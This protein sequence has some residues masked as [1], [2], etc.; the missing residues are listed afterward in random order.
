MKK[1]FLILFLMFSV[2]AFSQIET[3]ASNITID[4]GE[5]NAMQNWLDSNGGATA[6]ANCGT[7]TWSNDFLGITDL[8]DAEITVTFT[9]SNS[10]GD[11]QTLATLTIQ[12][13]Q[14]PTIISF[15]S[16]ITLECGS[17]DTLPE[18]VAEDNCSSNITISFFEDI[19]DGS[20]L[21]EEIIMRT[22]TVSDDC[23][24]ITTHLQTISFA[25]YTP[26]SIIT[27]ALDESV[28]CDG[29][30]NVSELNN[31]LSSNG[32]A[33]ASDTCST[34]SWSNDFTVLDS[35]CSETVSATVTFLATDDCGN[36]SSTTAT[37][38]IEVDLN[39]CPPNGTF[40]SQAEIDA[41]PINYPN[42][43]VFD[44]S[45]GWLDISGSDIVDLTPLAG[46]TQV[47]QIFIHDTFLLTD[48]DGLQNIASTSEDYGPF[49][50]IQDN[51]SL[52][53]I[54]A[55]GNLVVTGTDGNGG[56]GIRRNP[57]LSSLN[58]LQGFATNV[59][60]VDIQDND[61]L[62]N[63]N[64]LNNVLGADDLE[65]KD[66]DLLQ[67]LT[68]LF[69][70]SGSG[71]FEIGDN[72][73][74]ESLE[75]VEALS[76]ANSIR[77]TNN[78]ILSNISAMESA[79]IY[80][81]LTIENNPNLNICNYSNICAA[82]ADSQIVTT[83]NNNAPGCN[84]TAEV[85]FEC[86]ILPINDECDDA[87][88]LELGEIVQAYNELA[89]QSSQI[90]SCND[91]A[92][93]VDVWFSF[94]TTDSGLYDIV[95]EGGT[96]NLQLWEGDCNSLTQVAD[97]CGINQLLD[98]NLE[99]NTDY[100]IQVW[101]DGT[102]RATG[103]FDIAVY[104][105]TLSVEDNEFSDFELYPNPVNSIVNFK[106]NNSVENITVYNALGQNVMTV[107]PKVSQGVLDVSQL[108]DG[109]YFMKVR[110]NNKVSTFKV[111]KN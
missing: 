34:I 16:D 69:A 20:C 15:P 80:S 102:N 109:L 93:R 24:N 22:W 7:V 1:V 28:S 59:G 83:I 23:G 46:L 32:G 4:C 65:I 76:Y 104:N 25:D 37:F 33:I 35:D 53:D 51:Q 77:I 64:G 63:L 31:W 82:I 95:V 73:Q 9:A 6:L 75:G 29:S 88:N 85:A 89:T 10:C 60:F 38:T 56:I 94:S 13:T 106:A 81:I 14:A 55:L 8:C 30:G 48:L 107:T 36:T 43:T 67:N 21:G 19:S 57:V 17:D 96:Y 62:I 101:S 45:I 5:D 49:V 27:S 11:F 108:S 92:N 74:L 58:G 78:S 111:L 90:P 91:S 105:T 47:F 103:L 98:A 66:N 86:N 39:D 110:I 99:Y 3:E 87:I 44:E 2:T 52:S 71:S 84:S 68:G 72:D 70:F 41:F 97:A 61:S 79:Q 26:P 50:I 42:C 40:T 100:Y 54:S 18:L 12:D